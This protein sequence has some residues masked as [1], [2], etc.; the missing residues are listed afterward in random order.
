MY[1]CPVC[2]LPLEANE[3]LN[4]N[5]LYPCGNCGWPENQEVEE[6]SEPDQD[7]DDADS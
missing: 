4:G 5:V 1:M 2:G 3:E 6:V 7:D